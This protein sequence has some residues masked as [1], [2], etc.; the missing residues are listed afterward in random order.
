MEVVITHHPPSFLLA[1]A[2]GLPPSP[3]DGPP[4]SGPRGI[5]GVGCQ[6]LITQGVGIGKKQKRPHAD[7]LRELYG[8]TEKEMPSNKM[9]CWLKRGIANYTRMIA[10]GQTV[11]EFFDKGMDG[12]NR[13]KASGEIGSS[14]TLNLHAWFEG[15]CYEMP[16]L[17]LAVVGLV[18]WHQV[19]RENV[20][21]AKVPLVESKVFGRHVG[22]RNGEEG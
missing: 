5:R 12:R 2:R 8:M 13:K 17:G 1:R 20:Y 7:F 18:H 11:E 14:T 6:A 9:K 15:S 10:D 19:V 22:G 3:L 16:G 21:D 4:L